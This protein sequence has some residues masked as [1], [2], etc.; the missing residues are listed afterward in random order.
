MTVVSYEE[1]RGLDIPEAATGTVDIAKVRALTLRYLVVSTILLGAGGLLGILLRQSQ[2]DLDRI[3]PNLWYEVM[4]AHGLATFVGWAAFALMGVTWWVLAECGLPIQGWGWRFAVACFWTMTIGATGVVV[5]TLGMGFAGSWVFL[6]PL[7]FHGSWSMRATGIFSL[8]ILSVGLSI[9]AYCFGILA[10]V[11]G[12]GLGAKSRSWGNRLGCA[13]GFGYIW[14]KRFATD[15]P[16]P[17]PVLPLTV[18]AIDMIIATVPLA[19]LLVEMVVQSFFSGVTVDPVLAKSMLWWFGHPVVYLLLF[20]AV[21]V[22][23]HLIPRYAKRPLVAGHIIGVGWLIGVC[24]NVVIGAHH[25]YLDFPN[26]FQQTVNL[27]MQPLTYAVT[28]PS[29]LSIYSLSFT[30]YR[31]DFEWTPAARFLAVGMVSWLVAGLQGVGLATIQFDALAHNTLWVVG[32]F[33]NMA[34]LNIG[35]VVFASAYAFVPKLT[36]RDWYSRRLADWHLV[37]TVVGGYGSVVPWMLQGLEGAPRRWAV[38]P[39]RYETLS[40]IALPFVLLIAVGQA[41]FFYNLARTIGWRSVR[42]SLGAR[43]H[44]DDRVNP[45]ERPSEALGAVLA[46]SGVA[47]GLLCLAS[48]P[49]VWAPLGI[50]A[51]YTATTLGTMRQGWWAVLAAAVLMLVGLAGFRVPS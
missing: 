12:D 16:V 10:V 47:L 5:T 11:L 25:M 17:F 43:V 40:Q 35:L 19:V 31:S 36:G 45:T 38:L 51:G 27:G 4:T 41:I 49:L 34:L 8:S 39:H 48:K 9:F 46:G 15:R 29:A 23:Y 20:P 7:P 32:H 42:V 13:L 50:L 22:Y 24:A 26:T 6:Y 44:A 21:A 28:I 3:S 1:A 14:P 33:H 30:I 18:I 2:A 37:L